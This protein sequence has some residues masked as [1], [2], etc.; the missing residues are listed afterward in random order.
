MVAR[1]ISRFNFTR[2]FFR[3]FFLSK[4]K[5]YSTCF[6]AKKTKQNKSQEKRDHCKM[7]EIETNGITLHIPSI[8]WI[9]RYKNYVHVFDWV[10]KILLISLIESAAVGCWLHGRMQIKSNV[11]LSV[12]DDRRFALH[13]KNIDAFDSTRITTRNVI[14]ATKMLENLFS[15]SQG[16][17]LQYSHR[18]TS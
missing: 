3:F 2:N 18:I 10:C 11:Q 1:F 17:F 15:N 16:V 6:F 7:I 8:A 12:V 9:V 4:W 13:V 5:R 14:Q